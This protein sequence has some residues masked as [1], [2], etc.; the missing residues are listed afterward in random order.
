[1]EK[2]MERDPVCKMVITDIEECD[3]LV[4]NGKEY[5]FCSTFCKHLFDSSADQYLQAEQIKE[6]NELLKDERH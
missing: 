4:I 3:R 1:M 5:F 2:I 6:V